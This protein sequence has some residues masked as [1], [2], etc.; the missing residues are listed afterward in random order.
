MVMSTQD[1]PTEDV[2]TDEFAFGRSRIHHYDADD[3]TRCPIVTAE[4]REDIDFA[5][6]IP[7]L[8]REFDTLAR[9]Y[10]D[11]RQGVID[12]DTAETLWKRAVSK[13]GL[14][15]DETVLVAEMAQA[16]GWD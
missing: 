10:T 14:T 4:A 12:D 6:E 5:D 9:E 16:L 11:S 3:V 2:S 1:Q 7:R 15:D 13:V 8:R